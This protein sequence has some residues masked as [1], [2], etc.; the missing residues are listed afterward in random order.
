MVGQLDTG[1]RVVPHEVRFVREELA[2]ESRPLLEGPV[3]TSSL[4][5]ESPYWHPY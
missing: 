3:S 4:F 5:A 1:R 2:S